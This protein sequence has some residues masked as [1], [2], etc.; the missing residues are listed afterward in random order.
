MNYTAQSGRRLEETPKPLLKLIIATFTI[1]I[2][3]ALTNDALSALLGM[4]GPQEL[5]SLTW[6]G[7]KHLFLWQPF[8]FLFV[9]QGGAHGITFFYL[10]AL[11]FNMYILWILG[12]N[13]YEV[14]G[15]RSFFLFYFL[16]GILAG[17]SGIL[18]MGLVGQYGILSG[19]GPSI[20]ALIVAWSMLNPE[21]EVLFFF[22]LP[23]KAKWIVACILGAIFLIDLSQGNI[24]DLVFYLSGAFYGY[25]FALF[26]WDLKSPFPSMVK[27]ENALLDLGSKLNFKGRSYKNN[28]EER[29]KIFDIKTGKPVDDDDKFV[30]AML[31]KISR[32]GEKSLTS[33]ERRRLK[34]ISESKMK[35]KR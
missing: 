34:D 18:F 6:Y 1:S 11:F 15:A 9:E 5:L 22:I 30:D 16:T 8:T 27:L 4:Q 28:T 35:E 21:V 7:V 31:E 20:L 24:V 3:C 29:G 32:F 17:C 14:F 26:V 25:L 33:Q 12:S 23:M 10:L 2:F 13:L 19:P